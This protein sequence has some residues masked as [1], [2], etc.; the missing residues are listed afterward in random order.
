MEKK[1]SMLRRIL[2]E[3]RYTVAICGSGMM[4]EAGIVAMKDQSR[5]YDIEKKYKDSPE[6]IFTS[7]YYNARPEKFFEFYKNELLQGIPELT[8][9][10]IALAAME[11]AGKLQC[12]ITANIYEQARRAGCS[13]VINLHGS[14]YKNKCL[15]CGKE[16]P[17]E[18]IRDAKG[19][20]ICE[21]CRGIIRPEVSLYGEM[22]DSRLM[23]ETTTEIERAEVLLVLGTTLKSDV[24]G[25][26]IRYFNGKY[27]VVIHQREHYSDEK[28]DL[29]IIDQPKNVLSQLT[30]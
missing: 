23:C 1:V 6:E 12:I 29:V 13:H 3:S 22:V 28:A 5:A 2:E 20:P 4:E 30:Y 15:R 17:M 27:L 16:Y 9:S 19:I 21:E 7:A 25:N 10:G 8:Q 26:Y 24:F 11:R 14:I 18:Y